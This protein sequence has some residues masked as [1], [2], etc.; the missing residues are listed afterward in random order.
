MLIIVFN[1]VEIK[2]LK[3]EFFKRFR[4]KN[5]NFIYYYLE[6]KI[7]KNRKHRSM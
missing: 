3:E 2:Q 1:L 5:L 6:I 7:I 4:I